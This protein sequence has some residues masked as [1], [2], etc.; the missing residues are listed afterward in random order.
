MTTDRK[1]PFGSRVLDQHTIDK[2]LHVAE[3]LF[4][5]LERV[6]VAHE[7]DIYAVRVWPTVYE[8]ALC[9]KRRCNM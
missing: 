3:K 9:F 1:G 2:P 4:T 8:L 7:D 6:T 5:L